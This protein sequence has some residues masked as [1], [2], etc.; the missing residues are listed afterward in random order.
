MDFDEFITV[1]SFIG[2][3]LARERLYAFFISSGV[4]FL[5]KPSVLSASL[6]NM[7]VRCEKSASEAQQQLP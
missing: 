2:V 6:S 7:P 5:D 1:T 3:V 4:A